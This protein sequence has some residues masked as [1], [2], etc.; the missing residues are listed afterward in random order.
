[1]NLYSGI[2]NF[3]AALANFLWGTPLVILLFGGGFY[4]SII[5]RL[6]PFV[7]LR[8]GIDILAGKYDP[9]FPLKHAQKDIRLELEL[10]AQLGVNM[11]VTTAS[12]ARYES[13]LSTHGDDDFSAIMK[14]DK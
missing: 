2:D 7:H 12:N 3:M 6:I 1:M 9:N 13:V 10:A 4:F 11:P 14:A 5:S 8:H